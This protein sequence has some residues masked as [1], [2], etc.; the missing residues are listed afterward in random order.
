V[1]AIAL[2]ACQPKLA[3]V[4]GSPDKYYGKEF[5]FS[6][7]IDDVLV[8][9]TGGKAEV[10]H[11]VAPGGHRML[12]AMAEGTTRGGGER[13]RVRGFFTPEYAVGDQVFYDILVAN[14]VSRQSR[15]FGVP[16][17]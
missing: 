17:W 1:L 12:V 14:T 2:T 11:L 3:A 15:R 5:T 16:L 9:T 7:R 4:T 8:R 6:G 13:V 10:F